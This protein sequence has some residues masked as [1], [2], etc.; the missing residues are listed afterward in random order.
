MI[1][2][3]KKTTKENK[4]LAKL[5][6]ILLVLVIAIII[7][8]VTVKNKKTD[9]ENEPNI[10]VGENGEVNNISKKVYEAKNV[11]SVYEM[12]CTSLKYDGKNTK[13][14]IKI[15]NISGTETKGRLTK[16]VFLDSKGAELSN[17]SLYVR[18]IGANQEFSTTAS[19]SANIVD[20]Y[21]YKI[22]FVN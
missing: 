15:K 22:I 16:I 3:N 10:S 14:N 1:E 13:A 8:V 18:A 2:K 12:T 20:A 21:D 4:N 7:V 5:A 9:K 6:I 19:I 17:M 11:E